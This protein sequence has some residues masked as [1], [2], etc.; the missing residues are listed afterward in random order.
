MATDISAPLPQVDLGQGYF[1]VVD[2]GDA[3]AIVTRLAV[4]GT[5]YPPVDPL[6]TPPILLGAEADNLFA[7]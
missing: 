6:E 4:S 7:S 3:N 1:V 2:T 5:Y